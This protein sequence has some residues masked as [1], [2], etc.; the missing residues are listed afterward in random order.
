MSACLRKPFNGNRQEM[1]R[2]G[3]LGDVALPYLMHMQKRK[4]PT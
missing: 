1:E 3:Q 4:D 2:N